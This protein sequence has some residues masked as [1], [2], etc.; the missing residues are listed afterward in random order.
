M[1]KG[2]RAGVEVPDV[3]GVGMALDEAEDKGG[4]GSGDGANTVGGKRGW[5]PFMLLARAAT[6]ETTP[7]LLPLIVPPLLPP[8]LLPTPPWPLLLL[9]LLLLP[10]L[11]LAPE[12][13]L[14]PEVAALKEERR[15]WADDLRRIIG[16][17]EEEGWESELLFEGDMWARFSRGFVEWI[18][19]GIKSKVR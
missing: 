3:L 9:L 11:L 19:W 16:R 17:R 5:T 1:A 15:F 7:L 10:L 14:E 12:L 8:L 4:G 13:E 6:T 18:V 2:G